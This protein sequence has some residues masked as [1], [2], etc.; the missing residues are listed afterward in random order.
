M[1]LHE[2]LVHYSTYVNL[3]ILRIKKTRNRKIRL[4]HTFSRE[5][6]CPITAVCKILHGSHYENSQWKT[7]AVVMGLSFKDAV[8]VIDAADDF[9]RSKNADLRSC[10]EL[11]S[12]NISSGSKSNE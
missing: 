4:E 9:P 2:F 10:L 12:A 6:Y 1:T 7:A 5:E 8:S 3:G 11:A